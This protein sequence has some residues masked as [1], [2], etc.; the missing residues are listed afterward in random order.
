MVV[1]LVKVVVESLFVMLTVK[2]AVEPTFMVLGAKLLVRDG[3][4][5]GFT[6]KVACA[7]V[8]LLTVIVLSSWSVAVNALIG[9]SLMRFPPVIEL[10]SS[11]TSHSP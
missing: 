1:V 11:D 8:V 6:S 5:T 4:A 10:T 9:I 7:K 3:A 2:T